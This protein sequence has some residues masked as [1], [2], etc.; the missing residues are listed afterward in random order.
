MMITNSHGR[1]LHCCIISS[2]TSLI[3]TIACSYQTLDYL[4]CLL[5]IQ[6]SC[7]VCSRAHT[8]DAMRTKVLKTVGMRAPNPF[9]EMARKVQQHLAIAAMVVGERHT[10][11][12]EDFRNGSILTA[13]IR[14]LN[15]SIFH[16][17][18]S[19]ISSIKQEAF[20]CGG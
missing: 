4:R 17:Y 10:D 7:G 19:G 12:R 18:A 11:S 8:L 1:R 5:I 2:T 13:V 14:R 6:N 16:T 15:L 9:L 20:G 3:L